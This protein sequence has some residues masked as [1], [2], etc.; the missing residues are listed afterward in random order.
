MCKADKFID[1]EKEVESLPDLFMSKGHCYLAQLAA[2][3]ALRDNNELCNSYL[4]EG[5]EFFGHPKRLKQSTV[6]NVSSG[7]LGQGITMANGVALAYK[8]RGLP[9]KT[10]S[11]I[12]DG[13]F[14]EGSCN[15]AINFM[16]QH[17]LEHIVVLDN[18]KQESLTFTESILSNGN[19][20][21]RLSALNINFHEID[22]HNSR[23]LN[24]IIN[25]LSSMK[26]PCFLSLNT[27]KGKGVSFMEK[28]PVWHSRRFKGDEMNRALSELKGQL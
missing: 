12:G 6:F 16:S 17:Q 5:S 26:G 3:D 15:E 19:I 28:N 14:N 27:I 18:N 24:K 25:E 2:I 1:L 23:D 21:K 22:G 11:V 7:S 9:N 4:K 20:G 8:I 10:W 13:E